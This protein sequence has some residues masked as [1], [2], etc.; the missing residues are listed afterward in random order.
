MRHTTWHAADG[1]R[2]RAAVIELRGATK[3]YRSMLGRTV[4]AVDDLT[5]QIGDGEVLGIAGPNGA[6]KSTLLALLLGFQRPTSGTVTVDGLPPR[7][8][9]ERSGTGYVPELVTMPSRWRADR[10]LVRLATLA[11]VGPAELPRAVNDA[12]GRLGLEEH[13]T[14]TIKALSKGNLQRLGVAQATLRAERLYVFD[15]PTHGLDP[16]WTGKFRDLLASLRRPGTTI[17]IASH[18]LDELQRVADRVAIIDRGRLQRV[19]TTG[20]T[21]D[22]TTATYRLAVASG[23]DEVG[24]VFPGARATAR[25]EFDVDV[26]DITQLNTGLAELIRRGA[27][28]ASVAPAE[29]VLETQFREAVGSSSATAGITGES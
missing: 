8:F 3:I 5:L 20:Y 11:G 24:V 17:V 7:A 29:S 25:G 21:P 9:V 23:A 27:L 26:A 4:R 19:V 1:A 12:I 6:G 15:E 13:R 2:P 22:T 10:A 28:L 16:V 14:K 18:N